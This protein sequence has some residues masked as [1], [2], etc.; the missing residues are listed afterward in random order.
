MCDRTDITYFKSREKIIKAEIW[1]KHFFSK[2]F[3]LLANYPP[4]TLSNHKLIK[5]STSEVSALNRVYHAMILL[6][7]MSRYRNIVAAIAALDAERA[8]ILAG[9]A[10]MVCS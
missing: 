2:A 4:L 8:E 6:L 7:L 9:I 3:D 5:G 1:P 10:E